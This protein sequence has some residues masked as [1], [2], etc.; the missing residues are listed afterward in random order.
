LTKPSHR[1]VFDAGASLDADGVL[2]GWC[3]CNRRPYERL[4]VQVVLNDRITSTIMASRFR[5][6]LLGRRVGD[7]Y[8][9]FV[10]ALT[11]ELA[12][13]GG[14]CL[15]SV[16]E[17]SSGQIFW[18]QFVGEFGLPAGLADRMLT[19]TLLSQAMSQS[20]VLRRS[21]AVSPLATLPYEL[22]QLGRHLKRR[23]RCEF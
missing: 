7:G 13:F 19:M 8:H 4:V 3:W 1:E 21:Q 9:G 16:L 5:E 10:V 11:N 12:K 15:L 6:D 23:S 2:H 14:G 20:P 18:R 22:G 17:R